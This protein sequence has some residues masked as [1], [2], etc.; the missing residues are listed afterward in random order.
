MFSRRLFVLCRQKMN[1][2]H[3]FFISFWATW[4]A[5]RYLC[6]NR[7]SQSPSLP[8]LAI[9]QPANSQLVLRQQLTCRS[10]LLSG[11]V[12]INSPPPPP[13]LPPP[14]ERAI[15]SGSA[16]FIEAELFRISMIKMMT[17]YYLKRHTFIFFPWLR[18]KPIKVE[19]AHL[20]PFGAQFLKQG[21]LKDYFQYLVN[22][23]VS[24]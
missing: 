15:D 20:S 4:G 1:R 14:R 24:E 17:W 6:Y 23:Q 10:A 13:P 9:Y 5:W 16:T 22:F 11:S 18:F 2:E 21:F 12:I 19:A 8:L 7:Q 3:L